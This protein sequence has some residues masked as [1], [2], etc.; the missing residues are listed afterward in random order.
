MRICRFD[1]DRLGLVDGDDVLDVTVAA[2]AL[3]A[4]RWPL[5][6][7]DHAIAHLEAL[8]AAIEAAVDGAE[9]KALAE[10]TLLS[11]VANPSKVIAAPLNY[12]PHVDEARDSVELHAHSHTMDFDGYAT[13]IAKLGLFLKAAT[14]VVGPGQGVALA[15]PD[16]RNDPE[17]ELAAVIGARCKNVAEADALSAVAGYCIG[18][19]MTVRGP[20]ERSF[21]KSPDGYT[22]LGPWLVTADEIADPESL[23]LSIE[24]GGATRQSSN[25]RHLLV[26]VKAL[27]ALA[28]RWYTLHPGDVILTGTPDGVAPVEAGD[29]MHARV[30]GVGEMDVAVR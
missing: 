18:L 19:D 29:L 2:E 27:I 23:D 22:V 5:P 3:P 11:P 24:V 7:G 8:R 15:F 16:R 20:E 10:V 30:A 28:S 17:V 9:R 6:P 21:R 26:G 4:L 13:P 25:T 14:S 1:D 12:A